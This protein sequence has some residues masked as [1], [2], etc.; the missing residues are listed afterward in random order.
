MQNRIFIGR[1]N[2]ASLKFTFD[3]DFG[4]GG[5]S[6][7]DVITVELGGESYSSVDDPDAIY[8]TDDLTLV[9]SIG[10]VTSLDAGF[11]SVKVIGYSSTYDDGYVLTCEEFGNIEKLQV[12]EI[13]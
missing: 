12:I 10:D 6:N 13:S 1:D 4:D 8:L 11:Y 5:L 7:F 3:G 9:I 2:P